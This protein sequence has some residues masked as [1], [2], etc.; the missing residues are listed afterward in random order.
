[1][2]DQI[3]KEFTF[4]HKIDK[5][6]KAISNSS[7]I[8]KW[9][10]DA[11]FKAEVGYEYVFTATEEHG[12]TQIKGKVLEAVPYTLKYS[13]LVAESSVET[14]VSWNLEEVDGGTKLT[15]VHSGISQLGGQSAIEAFQHFNAGWDACLAILPKYLNDEE[16]QPAH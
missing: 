4:N 7:E 1:M 6:W 13:W 5:V 3:V 10:I 16:T 9:F 11:D 15:L 12:K 2:E 8:S 14:Y